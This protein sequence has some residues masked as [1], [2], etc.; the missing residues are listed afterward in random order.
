M[1]TEKKKKKK[2]GFGTWMYRG[3]MVILLCIVAFSGYKVYSIWNEYHSGTVAYD[4]I[5]EAAGAKEDKR[6][7]RRKTEEETE[8]ARLE[9]DWEALKEKGPDA[10]AWLRS[11][12]T[13]I[14]Y[15]VV[16]GADNDYYLYRIMT[17]EYNRKGSL[18]IDYRIAEPFE[19]FLT[20]IYG[21]RMMDD[22]MFNSLGNYFDD[23]EYFKK[24]GVMELYTPEGSFDLKL[25]GAA[26]VNAADEG[27][28]NMYLTDEASQEQYITWILEHNELLGYDDSVE[29]GPGDRIVMLSTC[30]YD[31][32]DDRIV[33]WGK[34][35]PVE[36]EKDGGVI[37]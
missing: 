29:V 12:D 16:Q 24:H 14:N 20:I 11:P 33:V 26:N 6:P 13:S 4:D 22:S 27:I 9:I 30:T 8:P 19:E 32:G 1:A 31:P 36:E 3:V 35:E 10:K 25:F 2:G 7:F 23:K 5:A 28:Y 21:H 37:G 17:G 18:F 15:P 34:L